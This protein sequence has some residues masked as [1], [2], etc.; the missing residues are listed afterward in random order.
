MRCAQCDSNL[1]F[2]RRI[3]RVV[4]HAC[5]EELPV[6]KSCPS[7]TAPNP[8]HLGAGSERV[9]LLVKKLFPSARVSRMDSDTMV[10]REHY[11]D[12]PERF[13]RGVLDG[14][15]VVQS[16]TPGHPAIVA[17][18]KHDYEGFARAES[19][20]RA[21]VGKTGQVLGPAEAP[22]ARLRGRHR[23]HVLVKSPR[24]SGAFERARRRLPD[25]PQCAR[26]VP[27]RARR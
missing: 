23:K 11:E 15:I 21:E 1:T 16:A 17:A 12:A 10:R 9:G 22:I 24:A 13:G 14:R 19:R 20:L 8:R 7:C 26:D 2:H 3:G 6:P 25:D 27:R 4:C 5:C 18:A